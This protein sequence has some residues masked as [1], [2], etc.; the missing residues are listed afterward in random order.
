MVF[1]GYNLSYNLSA[2]TDREKAD[3]FYN[4]GIDYSDS[5]DIKNAIESYRTSIALYPGNP[6]A[7]YNL[8]VIYYENKQYFKAIEGFENV[9]SLN[10]ESSIAYHGLGLCFYE[11]RNFCRSYICQK[12]AC[13]LPN[14]G[15]RNDAACQNASILDYLFPGIADEDL[16]KEIRKN[17][18]RAISSDIELIINKD[19]IILSGNGKKVFFPFSEK[20]ISEIIGPPDSVVN[21][22]DSFKYWYWEKYGIT[23][24]DDKKRLTV[25]TGSDPSGFRSDLIDIKGLFPGRITINTLPVTPKTHITEIEKRFL[26]MTYR[27]NVYMLNLRAE[28]ERTGFIINPDREGYVNRIMLY[29]LEK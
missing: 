27:Y 3:Y 22:E 11:L 12:K 4:R 25:I 10:K 14:N 1:S 17:R 23:L 6:A 29:M 20:D 19:T 15:K 9:L 28:Y 2:E 16:L 7:H 21:V 18:A 8:A 26:N 13:E 24:D 5:G